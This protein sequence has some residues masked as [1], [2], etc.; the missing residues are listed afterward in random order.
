MSE[1]RARLLTVFFAIT[2]ALTPALP[3]LGFGGTVGT[4]DGFASPPEV[5]AGYAF[6][7][8]GVI[9]ALALVYSVWQAL[10]AGG[11]SEAARQTRAT[12]WLLFALSTAWMLIAQFGGPNAALAAI[13]VVMLVLALRLIAMAAT[14]A[15]IETRA[16]YA[17]TVPL[18]GLYAGWLTLAAFLNLSSLA[19]DFGLAPLGLPESLYA[20][21]VIAAGAALALIM[22]LRLR[23]NVWY[24]AAALWGLVGVV[25]ANLSGGLEA[26]ALV[27]AGLAVALLLAEAAARRA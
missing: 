24:A 2:Q 3:A 22:V 12:A 13:I 10:P 21:A 15:E 16:A 4:R 23:G 18:F 25:V 6:S 20:G 19:R 11:T 26:V 9:F 14:A 5:P 7:I 17:L 8:W 27:A 1:T